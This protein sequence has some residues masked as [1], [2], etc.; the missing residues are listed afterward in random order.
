[1][2]AHR[3]ARIIYAQPLGLPRDDRRDATHDVEVETHKRETTGAR[4]LRAIR[5]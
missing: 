3:H 1:M 4:D 5:E 2:L